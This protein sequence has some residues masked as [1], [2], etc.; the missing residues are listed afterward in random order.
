MQLKI[1]NLI[2]SF[3]KYLRM[4]KGQSVLEYTLILI[5][6]TAASMIIFWPIPG[7]DGT[8]FNRFFR[9]IVDGINFGVAGISF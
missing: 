9:V 6:I 4:S 8:I 5:V 2:I 1:Q 3:K 7:E